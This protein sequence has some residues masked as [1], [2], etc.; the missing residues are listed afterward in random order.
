[1]FPVGEAEERCASTATL[2]QTNL[3]VC[4]SQGLAALAQELSLTL[5]FKLE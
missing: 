5:V 2:G 1:M 4:N 3:D